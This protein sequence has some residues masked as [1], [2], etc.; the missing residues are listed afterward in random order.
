MKRILEIMKRI[1]E[2]DKKALGDLVG[3]VL[4]G[5]SEEKEFA[6]A[7][8][9]LHR[10]AASKSVNAFVKHFL[11]VTPKSA[12][13]FVTA[14]QLFDLPAESCSELLKLKGINTDEFIEEDDDDDEVQDFLEGLKSLV[15]KFNKD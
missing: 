9:K 13:D 11:H 14:C 10:D 12:E 1:T 3:V 6:V 8:M 7:L 15:E 5:D 4:A 2:G